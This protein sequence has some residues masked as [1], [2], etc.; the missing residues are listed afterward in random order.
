M[1]RTTSPKILAEASTDKLWG[2][3]IKLNDP[4][5]LDTEKWVGPGWLSKMLLSIRE[6]FQ[7]DPAS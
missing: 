5:A 7:E 4:H 1:L 2:T 3:G 6:E